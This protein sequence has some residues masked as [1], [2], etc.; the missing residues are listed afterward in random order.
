LIYNVK[1][2]TEQ[3]IESA[4]LKLSTFT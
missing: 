3:T 2:A 4:N 1:L